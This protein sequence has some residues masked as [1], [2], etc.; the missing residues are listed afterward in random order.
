M[1][2]GLI[3][4]GVMPLPGGRLNDYDSLVE[5][6]AVK[7][8]AD[9]ALRALMAAGA[10]ATPSVRKGLLHEEAIVRMRCCMVLD[11]HLDAAA[12]PELIASLHHTDGRVRAW[13]LHALACDRCKE[14][15]CRP[16]EEDV[17]PIALAMLS[18][19]QSRHVRTV[20]AHMVGAAV[21]RRPDVARALEVAAE[22]DPHPVV[23][24]VARWYAPGGSIY[25][26]L[27]PKPVRKPK[28][29][30]T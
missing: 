5:Q 29:A 11:H 12:L 1:A 9:G 26:R 21:H 19:D 23:R 27:A 28:S 10:K 14:G 20:A 17:V 3:D 15:A 16:G 7:H 22:H 8:R 18:D 6:L 30:R 2:Q 13:A 24:K 4:T 25:A